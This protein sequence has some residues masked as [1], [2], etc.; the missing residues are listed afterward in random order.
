MKYIGSYFVKCQQSAD[1]LSIV[2]LNIIP[3]KLYL[4]AFILF[5]SC[6][7]FGQ[8]ITGAWKGKIGAYKTELKLI[9]KGD[10]LFGTSYYYLS[11]NNFRRYSIKGYFDPKTNDVIWWDDVLIE[12]KGNGPLIGNWKDPYLSIVD[13]NCPGEDKMLLE[14]KST[15]KNDKE[16]ETGPVNMQ[17]VANSTFADE[18]DFVLEN[19]FVGANHPEIIDSVAKIAFAPPVIPKGFEAAPAPPLPK[20]GPV[21]TPVD[22]KPSTKSPGIVKES[23]KP[24]VKTPAT[25]STPA[26]PGVQSNAEKF[27]SRNNKL[28][29]VIP[30]TAEKIELRFYDNAQ[31]DGDSIALFLNGK[32]IFEHIR[33]TEQPYTVFLK[34]SD[35]GDDN[36]LVMVAENLG[37]IPPNTSFMVAI[38]GDKRYE[39]RLYANENSSALIRFVRK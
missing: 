33:L 21:E 22:L 36:E 37:S 34:G 31:V 35:L 26:A 7:S 13:F 29:T 28:Q 11:K 25:I 18:W 2:A 17:K 15:D 4:F 12:S 30:I 1:D 20:F 38:V 6:Q 32:L 39:A 8:T 5:I 23:G 27:A 9:K 14:G 10:T 3:L 16:K 24:E 19:Y